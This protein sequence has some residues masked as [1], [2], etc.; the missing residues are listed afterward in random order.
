[1]TARHLSELLDIPI[2][3]CYRKIKLLE[4]LGLLTKATTLYSGRGRG[5]SLYSSRLKEAKLFY[6][7][8]RVKMALKVPRKTLKEHQYHTQE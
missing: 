1:M 3:E 8:N 4:S 2:V 7:N 5:I 6:S